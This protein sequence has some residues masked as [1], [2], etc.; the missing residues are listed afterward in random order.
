MEISF[1]L[2]NNFIISNR[3]QRTRLKF[4]LESIAIRINGE[5]I[6][7]FDQDKNF[8]FLV[9]KIEDAACVDHVG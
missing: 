4:D 8:F 6:L 7:I 3:N 9:I 5:T 1:F 2:L